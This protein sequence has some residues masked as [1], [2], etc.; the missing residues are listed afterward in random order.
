MNNYVPPWEVVQ[1][2][3]EMFGPVARD[4]HERAHRFLEEAI[5]L[6]HA[7]GVDLRTVDKISQRVYSRPAGE[8]AKEI[9][10]ARMTLNAFAWNIGVEPEA[11]E[12]REWDRIRA[13]PKE[14]WQRRH[15]AKIK[16]GIAG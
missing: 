7:A 13:I 4:K 10:Q 12:R 2:A 5:E 3:E 6:A 11:E 14:E 1:W 9:G 15:A 8:I 16:I